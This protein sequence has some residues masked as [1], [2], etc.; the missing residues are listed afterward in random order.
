M[1]KFVAETSTFFH[2][3]VEIRVIETLTPTPTLTD[4]YGVNIGKRSR[5]KEKMI[6]PLWLPYALVLKASL[7]K[8]IRSSMSSSTALYSSFSHPVVD[9]STGK[10]I[11]DLNEKLKGKRVALY[12]AAGWCPM[13]TTFE[14]ALATFRQSAKDAGKPIQL[15]YVSSDRS[16][17][18]H[19]QRASSLDMW[20]VPFEEVGA[21]LKRKYN[22]WSGS[23]SFEFGF[24]RRSGVP[25]LVVLDKDGNELSFVA[26][27][28]QGPKALTSWPLDDENGIW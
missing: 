2:V 20:T 3:L 15:V 27:E 21:D 14:P 13:C 4:R 18:A 28:A 10:E 9:P 16:P 5:R 22:I 8:T 25:A 11:Q 12:F 26:A 17:D 23:E 1:A 19:L 7:D 24:G 6:N